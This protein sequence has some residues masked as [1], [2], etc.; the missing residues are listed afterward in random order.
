MSIIIPGALIAFIG[1]MAIFLE[2]GSGERIAFLS[3]VMLTEVMFLV[4]IKSF[5]P[6]SK[7]I[8]YFG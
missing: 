3:T 4:M 7:T 6:I 5:V 2:R 1:L 8:P